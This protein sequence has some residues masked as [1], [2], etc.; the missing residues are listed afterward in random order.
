M[1]IYRKH[2]YTLIGALFICTVIQFSALAQD[3]IFRHIT[4]RD[5]LPSGFIWTMMQDSKGFIW[6]GTTDGLVRYNGYSTLTFQEIPD[7]SSS[8]SGNVVSEIIEYNNSMFL[9]AT[10][11]GLDLFNPATQKFR[12]IEAPDSLAQMGPVSDLLLLDEQTLWIAATNGLYRVD[13]SA[14]DNERTEMEYYPFPESDEDD[15]LGRKTVAADNKNNLWVGTNSTLLKFNLD[16]REFIDIG[17]VSNRVNEIISGTIWD[18]LFTS[19]NSL[20]ISSTEGLAILEE[21]DD[22]IREVQQLGNY[23]ADALSQASFQS[24]TEDPEG[25]IWLGTG[26][27]GAIHWNPVSGE[28]SVYRATDNSADTIAS[29]DVHYAFEDEEGNIWFGYHFLGASVMYDDSWNYTIQTPYP[30][31]PESD[32]RNSIV[33]AYL[34]DSGTTWATTTTGVIKGLESQEPVYFEFDA[35]AFDAID[36][37]QV[38]MLIPVTLDNKLFIQVINNGNAIP[39]FVIFDKAV[40]EDPFSVLEI[41]N[42]ITMPPSDRVVVY[43]DYFYTSL[44]NEEAVLQVNFKT[45]ETELIELPVTGTYS[46]APF[47]VSG[48]F[49]VDGNE[50]YVQAYWLGTPDG[51]VSEK[52]IMNLDTYEFRPHNLVVDYPIRD[53]QAPLISRYDAGVLYI[54]SSTGLIRLDNLNNSYSVLFEDQMSLLREGS[55]LMVEDQDGYI[56]MSNLT[57]LT[58][59]DPLTETVEYFEIPLDRFRHLNTFPAP[60]QDGDI[61]FPGQGN[62]LRFDPSDLRSTQPAGETMITSLQ[63]GNES[64]DLLYSE[65]GQNIDIESAQNTLTFSF[66]GLDYR[67]PASINYRYRMLGSENEQWTN[68]GTQRSVFIPNLPAGNYTFE[69]QS[70]SQFGSFNGQTASISFS[71]LPPWW[72][73]YPAYLLYLFLIGGL[74]FGIDRRQRKKLIQK[75]RER[76]REKELEQAREIEK[77]Y[78]NLKAAQEQLVQQEK[79][80]SLGQLTAGI[81][82]EIKNPLNFVN[83]FSELSIELVEEVR[84]EIRDL[85]REKGEVRGETERETSNVKGETSSCVKASEDEENENPLSRGDGIADGNT[86]GVLDEAENDGFD[87]ALILEILDD[88]EAN[89]KTIHKHGSRADSIVKSM[90]QHSRGGSGEMEPT[91]LNALIR[92]YVNLSFHGMRAGKDP[93]NVDIDLQLDESIDTVPLVAEDFSR[94]ILNLTNNAFDAMREKTLQGFQTLGGLE[95]YQPKLTVRTQ[96]MD[97]TVTIKIEDN[98]PGIPEEMKGKILQPFF[99][100]KKGTEGTGLGLSITN[101]IIKAHGGTINIESAPGEGTTFVITI[102]KS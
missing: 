39:V 11:G 89:L 19:N 85:R 51:A 31:L 102:T 22:Q 67:D 5:G 72:N 43:E 27:I 12:L 7:D 64:Y 28:V 71:V 16:S 95:D 15:V 18:M 48:A 74:I 73:T 94:V 49:H 80:A 9:V 17:P 101:D 4:P 77:A 33:S 69:V 98:G 47:Q 6:M 10:N 82:H 3:N 91:D 55:R 40:S 1:K 100:T 46:D 52:F 62:Y 84:Q 96:K 90:L 25:N 54:N 99:T 30:E 86:R 81:A 41:Q 70:G 13:P 63:A 36:G 32:P 59:L 50:L 38:L 42:E 29:D 56:W 60:L 53:I 83:N 2:V 65:D 87:P 35:D 20:L 26:V 45:N 37:F 92:E 79:L 8:I 88:I 76:A 78:K 34:D 75:E 97:N 61:I 57:G 58:R 24:I 21:G 66:F 68:V 44:F 93:I 23:G 14:A